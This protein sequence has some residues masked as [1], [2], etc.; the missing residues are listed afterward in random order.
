MDITKNIYNFFFSR[1]FDIIEEYFTDYAVRKQDFL[2]D[3]D[4]WTKVLALVP[5]EHILLLLKEGRKW[6]FNDV[7]NTFYLQLYGVGHTVKDH[8]DSER[9]NPL[10]P[11]DLLFP[12]SSKKEGRN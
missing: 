4:K 12:I 6:V 8:S 11:H 7:L 9:G 5:D 10:L 1:S 2:E 3:E